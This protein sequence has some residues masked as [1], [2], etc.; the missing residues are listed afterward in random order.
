MFVVMLV[1]CSKPLVDYALRGIN[2]C[3]FAYGQTGSGKTYSIFGETGEK[4][5][6]I[7]RAAD[8]LF[9]MI[10]SN[11]NGHKPNKPARVYTL[12]VSFLEIYCDRI[13]DL[14]REYV[15][16]VLST[17]R[18]VSLQQSSGSDWYLRNVRRCPISKIMKRTDSNARLDRNTIHIVKSTKTQVSHGMTNRA[19]T[20]KEVLNM[21]LFILE[22]L[23]I[24]E[25]AQGMVYVKD[26]SMIE[27]SNREE[28][29][30]PESDCVNAIVQ[31]GLT[32]RAT[33]ETKMNSVSSR[34]HTVFT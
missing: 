22:N 27:V 11:T 33:H 2:S 16:Y 19:S 23:E 15:Q 1:Q 10:E 34:S 20:T 4:D 30:R 32:L 13:R 24:H 5:G 18:T 14:G 12:V 31:M 25:D 17:N 8:Y 28:V 9:E 26:L 3:C 7:P 6:I 21:T 29:R